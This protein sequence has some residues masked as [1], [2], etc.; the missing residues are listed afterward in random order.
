MVTRNND[1]PDTCNFYWTYS[2]DTLPTGGVPSEG[3]VFRYS[4]E[5]AAP[6]SSTSNPNN[7]AAIMGPEGINF[8]QS[9]LPK[10]SAIQ[11]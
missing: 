11:Q 2:T 10:K 3:T 8:N 4:R 1:N 6:K 5:P 9:T 7:R